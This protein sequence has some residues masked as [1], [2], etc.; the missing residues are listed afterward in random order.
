MTYKHL[1]FVSLFAV[2]ALSASAQCHTTSRYLNHGWLLL[3]TSRKTTRMERQPSNHAF[4][5]VASRK[6]AMAGM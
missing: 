5:L 4:L 1:S 3:P 2:A 6:W